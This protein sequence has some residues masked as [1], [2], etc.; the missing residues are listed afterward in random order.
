MQSFHL[1]DIAT[2]KNIYVTLNIF[3]AFK[4]HVPTY[5][6]TP[7]I[8]NFNTPADFLQVGC[9]PRYKNQN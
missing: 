6:A 8:P 9:K 3:Q 4:Y 1:V 2:D 5:I 7:K